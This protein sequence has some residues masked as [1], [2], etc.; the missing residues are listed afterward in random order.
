VHKPV[1]ARELG[2]IV[3]TA[4]ESAEVSAFGNT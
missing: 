4:I 1:K 3:K 2:R